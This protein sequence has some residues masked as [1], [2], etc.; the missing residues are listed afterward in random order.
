MV[1]VSRITSSAAGALTHDAKRVHIHSRA[2]A[3]IA[4]QLRRLQ[5]AAT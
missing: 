1:L 4:Q 3:P 5:P 2:H